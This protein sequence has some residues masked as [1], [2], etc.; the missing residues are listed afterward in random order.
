MRLKRT[1]K[2]DADIDLVAFSD[3]AFLLIIFFILTT[4]FVKNEGQV[5]DMPSG[6]KDPQQ[7]ENEVITLNLSTE[8]ILYN[9]KQPSMDV[10]ALRDRLDSESFA[11]RPESDRLV[12]IESAA[13]VKCERYYAVVMAVA[14][15]GG[16]LAML[17][18]EAPE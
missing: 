9:G 15:A 5:L 10:I 11:D 4:T 1:K 16:V 18:E 2:T 13:D 6:S 17:E 14:D 8:H 3:I 7:T 12:L